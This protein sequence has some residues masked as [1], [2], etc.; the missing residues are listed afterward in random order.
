M[1]QD[2]QLTAKPNGKTFDPGIFRAF[3]DPVSATNR[4]GK[5][6]SCEAQRQASVAMASLTPRQ[7][8]VLNLVIAG[9]PS[10][11]IAFNLGIS[12][13]TV[14]NHRAAIFKKTGTTSLPAMVRTAI[15]TDCVDLHDRDD[16]LR[17]RRIMLEEMEHRTGNS[18][19]LMASLLMLKARSV[20]SEETRRH[21]EDAH[22]RIIA[23][24]TMQ[25]QLRIGATDVALQ[26]YLVK[27]CETLSDSII[28]ENGPIKLRV[29]AGTCILNPRDAVSIGLVV[30]EL[31]INALKY[32][33]PVG[34]TGTIGVTY[35]SHQSG[36]ELIVEDD[37]I[38]LQTSA[39]PTAG[40]S[41][42]LGTQLVAAL[43]VQLK[44]RVVKEALE[45]GFR[46]TLVG[47]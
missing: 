35:R 16:L 29:E 3:A 14:E 9:S 6:R 21:L 27:L 15:C 7:R 1:T 47:T 2:A 44:S 26:P 22:R 28:E 32:A 20:E 39:K 43:A 24:S 37:G 40:V 30:I 5:P 36:W 46:V 34:R 18:L 12:Q 19:Q 11:L 10:K 23:F 38:G 13:R 4:G 17:D 42:G 31:V 41:K 33:F 45:P 25:Q 8:E